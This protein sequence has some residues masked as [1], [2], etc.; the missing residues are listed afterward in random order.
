MRKSILTECHRASTILIHNYFTLPSVHFEAISE[1]N[2]LCHAEELCYFKE[3][4]Q[5]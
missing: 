3:G 2:E 1:A 4:G 5:N